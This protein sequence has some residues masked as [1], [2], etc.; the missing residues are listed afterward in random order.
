MRG[1]GASSGAWRASYI[2]SALRGSVGQG[3]TASA[4]QPTSSA[5][6]SALAAT[7]AALNPPPAAR[8]A[9]DNSG[10]FGALDGLDGLGSATALS[11][12]SLD[13]DAQ[14]AAGDFRGGCAVRI[15]SASTGGADAIAA[16]HSDGGEGNDAASQVSDTT[17]SSAPFGA[18]AAGLQ[19]D[20]RGYG[21]SASLAASARL[22]VLHEHQRA[23]HSQQI[24]L[25]D[26]IEVPPVLLHSV[27]EPEA[28][29]LQLAAAALL[30]GWR[31]SSQP[32]HNLT[33]DEMAKCRKCR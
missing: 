20:T 25:R 1:R 6:A 9:G 32:Q 3:S 17:G 2:N 10:V 18:I 16:Q 13:A 33:G 27:P 22:S 11:F 21:V 29:I 19:V 14:N 4:P 24:E 8:N 26:R 23:V 5:P 15:D 28:P 7:A 31:V 12:A 30:D